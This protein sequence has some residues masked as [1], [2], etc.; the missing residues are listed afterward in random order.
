MH[1]DRIRDHG[2]PAMDQAPSR[3][4]STRPRSTSTRSTKARA[5]FPKNSGDPAP[6]CCNSTTRCSQIPICST[7]LSA[8]DESRSHAGIFAFACAP[9]DGLRQGNEPLG[10]RG[11]DDRFRRNV[12]RGADC[13]GRELL[14]RKPGL[15]HR[16]LRRQIEFLDL[17]LGDPSPAGNQDRDPLAQVFHENAATRPLLNPQLIAGHG[18]ITVDQA[19][20]QVALRPSAKFQRSG[21]VVEL[22]PLDGIG[23]FEAKRHG[24]LL[25]GF[26]RH[27]SGRT[28]ESRSQRRLLG[29]GPMGVSLAIHGKCLNSKS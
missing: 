14:D 1:A 16:Q 3:C 4:K 8:D 12:Y 24:S 15:A 13:G 11:V 2:V 7:V 26:A 28:E 10:R 29:Q 6:D 25:E 21:I 20:L 22:L 23:D 18:W 9:R 19:T 5:V 27:A 17:L